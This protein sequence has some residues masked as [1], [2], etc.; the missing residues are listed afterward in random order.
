[1]LGLDE[2]AV[3]R[4]CYHG[5]LLVDGERH[6]PVDLLDGRSIEQCAAGLREHPAPEIVCRD[7]T[8]WYA[9]GG[10]QGAPQSV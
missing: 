7:R 4:G 3:L 8:G 6:R 1:V 9:D 5:A 2:F 10:R